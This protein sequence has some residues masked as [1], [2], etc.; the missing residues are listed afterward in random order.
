MTPRVRLAP[1][2]Y[3]RREKR[4]FNART[5]RKKERAGGED[6][7]DGGLKARSAA[8]K[9]YKRLNPGGES[10]TPLR[11]DAD[12][13]AVV[14]RRRALGYIAMRLAS[15]SSPFSSILCRC[16]LSLALLFLILF[17]LRLFLHFFSFMGCA[18]NVTCNM[19]IT[20]ERAPGP[21]WMLDVVAQPLLNRLPGTYGKGSTTGQRHASLALPRRS[22]GVPRANVPIAYAAY[23]SSWH[24]FE[25]GE[26][27][28]KSMMDGAA[29]KYDEPLH[30]VEICRW[31][32]ECYH[33]REMS[34]DSC[35][36]YA[37]YA[38]LWVVGVE[39]QMITSLLGTRPR[40]WH[41]SFKTHY[42]SRSR[43]HSS[44]TKWIST[45]D[46][47]RIFSIILQH[48]LYIYHTIDIDLYLI[49]SVQ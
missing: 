4:N 26:L 22:V 9:N 34:Y 23:E 10:Y 30:L 42:V 5:S 13:I 45:M 20:V 47:R 48:I 38:S 7:W 39:A 17:L 36:V 33:Y 19:V 24:F 11:R 3:G 27:P 25:L 43:A 49:M 46:K 37:C 14:Y 44:Y 12:R 8:P 21:T 16:H 41:L 35:H 31:V 40:S 18:D 32:T 1:A 6:E 28:R 2:I 29:K 15:T